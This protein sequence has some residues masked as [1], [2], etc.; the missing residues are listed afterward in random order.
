MT[1]DVSAFMATMVM[2][3]HALP[4][5]RAVDLARE[6][7]GLEVDAARLTGERDENFRLTAAGGVDYVLKVAHPAENPAV[8]DLTTAALLHLESQDPDLPCPRVVRARGGHSRI[9]FI[10]DQRIERTARLLTYL[11]GRPLGRTHRSQ[12]M[13]EECGRLG[14]RLVCALRTFDHPAAHSAIV[15]DVRHAAHLTRLLD[16][17]PDFP[18]RREALA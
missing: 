6:Y 18:C 10:D 9:R 7:Y 5:P 11:P 4:L 2:H 1:D 16:Q 17:Q 12:R 3:P 8:T 14:G 15:W 13:R